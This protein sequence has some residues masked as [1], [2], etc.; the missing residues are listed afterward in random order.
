[1]KQLSNTMSQ[2][3][4]WGG[5]FRHL[6]GFQQKRHVS[7]HRQTNKRTTNPGSIKA[8][9][10]ESRHQQQR[11]D[12]RFQTP[13]SPKPLTT[14]LT[15]KADQHPEKNTKGRVHTGKTTEHRAE[16]KNN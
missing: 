6:A 5:V 1:M 3:D 11:T 4:H 12:Q 14:K 13:P 9:S 7:R 2:R 16:N 15:I 10:A 8:Q